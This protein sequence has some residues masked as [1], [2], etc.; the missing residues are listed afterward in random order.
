MSIKHPIAAPIVGAFLTCA[1]IPTTHGAEP[2][3]GITAAYEI[4]YLKW[5][6]NHHLSALRMTELAAGTDATRDAAVSHNEGTSPSPGSAAVQS[7]ARSEELR[8]LAR[9]NNRMQREEILTAQGF[10]SKWYG[11]SYEPQIDRTAQR[12]IALL[13]QATPGESFDH[14]FIEVL[15]RH[16]EIALGPSTQCQVSVDLQHHELMRYCAN[17]VHSQISD[18]TD[19][20][21]MLCRDFSFCDYRPT[22]GLKGVHSGEEGRN[23]GDTEA[24]E[25][26]AARPELP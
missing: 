18:I 25:E 23:S 11:I 21:E 20:R 3:R 17:I 22:R 26:G 12:Q 7:K 5:I 19:M 9:R 10:L 8:S 2:G 15:S 1:L 6:A 13:E 4:A 16:H 14:L 24:E